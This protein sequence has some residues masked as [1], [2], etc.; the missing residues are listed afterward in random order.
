MNTWNFRLRCEA[1]LHE[2]ASYTVGPPSP[3]L[4]ICPPELARGASG[5]LP[6]VTQSHFRFTGT[7]SGH[8]Q[9]GFQEGFTCF[10]LRTPPGRDWKLCPHPRSGL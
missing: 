4:S 10:S 6:E 9:E 3:W 2:A 7:T 8:A 1:S 5:G